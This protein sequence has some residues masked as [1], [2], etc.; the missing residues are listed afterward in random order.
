MIK[1]FTHT[2]LDGVGCAVLANIAFED[3][4]DIT[5]CN[6]DNVNQ[7]VK[8][9]IESNKMSEDDICFIT[10]ISVTEELAYEIDAKYDNV[11]LLDHH[12]TALELNKFTWCN[13][14]IEDTVTGIKTS[15][16]EMFYKWLTSVG[17]LFGNNILD[18]F[19]ETVRNYDTW[20]WAVIGDEGLVCKKV[21]DLFY[22]YG[23]EN[24]INWCINEIKNEIFPR[25]HSEDELLLEMK[26]KEIDDYI[27]FK[28][29]ELFKTEMLGYKCGIVFAERFFSELGNKLCNLN[30]DIYFVAM[31]DTDGTIS[32]RS[33]KDN[34]DVGKDIA[35]IYGGGGHPKAAGSQFDKNEFL[36]MTIEKL[37]S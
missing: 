37:F 5:Y 7:N 3:G 1:L 10:D 4:V 28:N 35:K 11:Y 16:T 25:L 29:K 31:I 33:V 6:Y 19:A 8:E 36:L 32:Y 12:P 34:I 27:S 9:F 14:E 30:P 23:R 15:G 24:F 21:N 13:V 22:I 26:Q 2:D 20:R 17:Y 18:S